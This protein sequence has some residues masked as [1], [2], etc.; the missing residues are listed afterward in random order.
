MFRVTIAVPVLPSR[1]SVTFF[2]NPVG[3]KWNCSSK[4][5]KRINNDLRRLPDSL[6]WSP[7]LHCRLFTFSAVQLWPLTLELFPF[8]IP[9]LLNLSCADTCTRKRHCVCFHWKP[10]KELCSCGFL[11]ALLTLRSAD[12]G[13]L[14]APLFLPSYPRGSS[15]VAPPSPPPLLGRPL[16]SP[17]SWMFVILLAA[18][19]DKRN[20][21]WL[22]TKKYVSECVCL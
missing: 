11:L 7:P 16:C 22:Q 3:N 10:A 21:F 5:K 4:E 6:L 1:V 8:F 14:G 18:A 12:L 15:A 13:D 20:Q 9:W 17:Q 19:S 2:L